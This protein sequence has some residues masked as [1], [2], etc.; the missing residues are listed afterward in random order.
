MPKVNCDLKAVTDGQTKH[1][2]FGLLFEKP[3][4]RGKG[5]AGPSRLELSENESDFRSSI[6]TSDQMVSVFVKTEE[7]AY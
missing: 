1:K 2:D 6:R 7:F 4:K 3:V 5:R